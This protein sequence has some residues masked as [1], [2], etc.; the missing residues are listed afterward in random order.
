[1]AAAA[2]VQMLQTLD[3]GYSADA[4]EVGDCMVGVVGGQHQASG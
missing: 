1:M 4:V 2:A 3:V